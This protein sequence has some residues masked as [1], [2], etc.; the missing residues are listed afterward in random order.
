MAE[1]HIDTSK[2]TYTHFAIP[3]QN[4]GWIEGVNAP[5]LILNPGRYSFQVASRLP[6]SFQ[7][8][9]TPDGLI[10]YPVLND[11]FLD[12]RGTTTLGVKGFTITLDG[13]S[14][15]HALLPLNVA[16]VGTLSREQAHELTLPPAVGYGFQPTSRTVADFRFDVTTDGK[17]VIDPRYSGFAQASGRNLTIRGYT[18]S[19]DGRQLSHDLLM[20]NM[21]G[22]STVLHRDRVEA[23]TCIPAAGYGFQPTSRIEADFRF[24]VTTDGKVVIDPRYSGFAQASGRNLV[25]NGYRVCLDTS[26]LT[27]SLSPSLLNYTGGPLLPGLSTLTVIPANGYT[28]SEQDGR[29]FQFSLD[30]MGITQLTNAPGGVT[31]MSDRRICGVPDDIVTDLQI[32]LYGSPKS[33]WSR[34]NLTYSIDP[35]KAMGLTPTEI[36]DIVGNAFWQWEAADYPLITLEPAAGTADIQASFGGAELNKDFGTPLGVLGSGKFPEIGRLYFD[37]AEQWTTERLRNVALHEIGHTLGLRHSNDPASIMFPVSTEAQSIDP[38]SRDALRRLYGWHDQVHLSDRATSDRPALAAAGRVSF[39]VSTVAL[40][41]VWKG[42]RDDHSF[43]ES[44]LVNGDW[45][46]QSP[47]PGP[48]SSTHSPALTSYA[49]GDGVSGLIM[50]WR[51]SEGDDSLYWAKN[52]GT[53]WTT[54][55]PIP[56]V[57]SSHRPATASFGASI[58]MAWKGV[59]DDGGIYWSRLT[60]AGW[61]PQRNVSGVGTSD[62]PALVAFRGKLFMFWKGSRDDTN[63]WFSS[64]DEDSTEWQAQQVVSYVS[65]EAPGGTSVSTPVHV[66]TS[67]GPSA[68]VDGNR[69]M[70]AWKGAK[71]DGGIYFS[72]FDGNG[73]T[74]QINVFGVGTSQGPAVCS[75]GETLFMAW[76]G[77]EADN[78]IWWSQL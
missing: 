24:D 45:S 22:P 60:E 25:I 64:L 39:T 47:I 50:T 78:T 31:I 4:T 10:D 62:S 34:R 72:M 70:L 73:F 68:T 21:Y 33:R 23:F 11:G 49:V 59:E 27:E 44:T 75:F 36:Y 26:E 67:R 6:A 77:S 28:L 19:V 40:H 7:F 29:V 41:M 9:V 30:A 37:S 76:K 57:G 15:S 14:L 56:D 12:G 35:A 61:E 16:G 17:V 46:P 69:I 8:T 74:G 18:V 42:S 38:E 51:G 55:Q 58:H 20:A 71:D 3:E 2:L 53:E 54:P 48:F 63:I 52:D 5:S 13:T 32:K 1:I 65:S 43:Y 66:G